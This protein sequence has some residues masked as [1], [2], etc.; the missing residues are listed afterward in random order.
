MKTLRHGDFTF[1]EIS[2]LPK[3]AKKIKNKDNKYT[4]AEGEATGH[5]HTLHAPRTEDMTFY[6]LPDGSYVVKLKKEAY[7][8][9]PEHSVKNDLI[10]PAGLYRLYQRRER[11][12]FQNV[13]R[14]VID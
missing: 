5:F 9:H 6:L 4:F 11:D 10:V 14:K 7:A 12:W 13:V 3:G 8:T 1:A 2:E